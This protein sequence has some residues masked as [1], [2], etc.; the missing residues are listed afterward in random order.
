MDQAQVWSAPP[1]PPQAL[2]A[3]QRQQR[4][5]QVLAQAQVAK[6]VD[7]LAA[8]QAV[9][10]GQAADQLSPDAMRFYPHLARLAT[11]SANPPDPLEL[12]GLLGMGAGLTPSGDDILLGLLLALTRWGDVLAPGWDAPAFTRALLT[13]AYAKTTT[14]S[15]NLI[16]CA[17]Q[18]QADERL[19][20]AA[21]RPADGRTRCPRNRCTTRQLGEFVR[22]RRPV[23]MTLILC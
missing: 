23:W 2:P 13:L 15:A 12:A 5:N 21:G 1:R 16:E 14:L 3:D 7:S 20:T 18:G 17:S 9:R 22:F 4:L 19:V 8:L 11:Q 6:Q 10:S